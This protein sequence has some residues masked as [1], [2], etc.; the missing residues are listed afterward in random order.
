MKTSRRKFSAKFKSKVALEALKEQSTLQ[1][2]SSKYEVHPNQ[3]AKWKKE[4][5]EN[6]DSVFENKTSS[7]NREEDNSKLYNKIGKMQVEI[8]FLKE[9]LGK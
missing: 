8:D 3:I 5:L 4:L 1:E 7:N 6:A 9:V 2:L